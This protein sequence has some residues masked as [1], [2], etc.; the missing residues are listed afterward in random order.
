M[1]EYLFPIKIPKMSAPLNM[2]ILNILILPNIANDA[3]RAFRGNKLYSW[4]C[5]CFLLTVNAAAL[6]AT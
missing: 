2:Y 3:P 1:V 5:H 6:P 4:V